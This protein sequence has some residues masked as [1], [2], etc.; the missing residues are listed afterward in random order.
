MGLEK[1]QISTAQ[2]I[3]LGLF[4][5]IGDMA[6]TYPSVMTAGA[7]E[8]AWIAGLISIPL[9]L[10]TLKL[11]ITTA[12]I[13]PNKTIIELS[14]QILG[15]WAGGAVA[16]SY[17]FF[18]SLLPLPM[19]G[20]LKILCAHRFTRR[21]RGVIRFMAIVLLV[22]GLRL[23]LETLGR[24]A[25]IFLPFFTVFLIGMLALLIPD[26][27]IEQIYPIM[28]TPFPD[29]L[30]TVFFGVF[31]PF[32]ELCVFFMVYPYAKN[33]AIQAGIYSS[34]CSSEGLD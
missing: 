27:R 25:Q 10:A 7:H 12:N 8:D 14:Q 2:M 28:N 16:L 4:T 9:G 19:S 5:L 1:D 3:V 17:L 11:M 26:M 22:Y 32:G 30:H 24:A 13:D 18:F 15:K 20:K 21:P 34:P 31:Y 33:K 29:M 23:G 6:L